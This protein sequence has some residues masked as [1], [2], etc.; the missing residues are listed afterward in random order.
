MSGRHNACV[1]EFC[2]PL[3]DRDRGWEWRVC[4]HAYMPAV[5]CV[6][7][8]TVLLYL[9]HVCVCVCVHACVCVC[10]RVCV[11]VYEVDVVPLAGRLLFFI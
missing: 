2:S 9:R 8:K 10:M 3:S 1:I 6:C 7:V 5:M 4:V 11:Y